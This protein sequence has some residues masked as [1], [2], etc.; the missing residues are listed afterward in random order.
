MIWVNIPLLSGFLR[1]G[2][3]R[4]LGLTQIKSVSARPSKLRTY[5]IGVIRVNS[6][7]LRRY[8]LEELAFDPRTDASGIG[9]AVENRIVTLTGHVRSVAD[10]TAV[11]NAV[12]RLKGVRGIV[13]DIEVHP[14]TEF[15]VEDEEI[16]KRAASILVWRGVSPHDSITI[17]VENG[18]VTLSGTVDWQFQKSTIEEDVRRLTGVTGVSSEVAIR[19]VSQEGDIQRSIK[20]AMHRLAEVRSSQI[21]VAVDEEGHVELKG[22]VVDWQARNAVEDAAWMVPGVRAVDN[23]V[24]VC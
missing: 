17:T 15:K 6:E 19:S 9:V 16:A 18:H 4:K 12:E 1:C 21:N 11:V 14:T 8:V 7:R 3:L 23:R 13:V 10:K 2:P 22:R 20:E 5:P 24:R